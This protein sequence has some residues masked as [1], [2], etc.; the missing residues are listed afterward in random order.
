MLG[1]LLA[2]LPEVNPATEP[3]VALRTRLER[4][5]APPVNDDF[6]Y[7]TAGAMVAKYVAR[8]MSPHRYF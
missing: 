2:I 5:S 1:A 6:G 8:M 7:G 4:L 3:V